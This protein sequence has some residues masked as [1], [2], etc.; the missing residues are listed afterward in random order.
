MKHFDLLPYKKVRSSSDIYRNEWNMQ[1][2]TIKV[3]SFLS[4]APQLRTLSIESIFLR[5]QDLIQIGNNFHLL[6]ELTLRDCMGKYDVDKGLQP[7]FIHCSNLKYLDISKNKLEGTTFKYLPPQLLYLNLGMCNR[8][9]LLAFFNVSEK[10]KNLETLI[11]QFFNT[12]HANE[13]LRKLPKL[14]FL[15]L[16][17]SAFCLNTLDLSYL[18]ELEV[19]NLHVDDGDAILTLRSLQECP[20]LRAL[21][22]WNIDEERGNFNLNSQFLKGMNPLTHLSLHDFENLD[23]LVDFVQNS[24]LKVS[25]SEI[26]KYILILY[27]FQ[28]LSVGFDDN[29]YPKNIVKNLIR[30]CVVS[31]FPQK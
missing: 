19:V 18:K 31:L 21:E 29:K 22:V 30:E 8:L 5:Q 7:I 23:D 1:K 3:F 16:T 2:L 27:I 15:S 14:R 11:L 25:I 13:W 9:P 12:E 6:E 28:T 20:K 26:S 10:A 24:Q 4:M 17:N